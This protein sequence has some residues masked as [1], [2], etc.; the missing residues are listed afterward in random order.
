MRRPQ[1][2]VL[3]TFGAIFFLFVACTAD[4]RSASDRVAPSP[5]DADV[6]TIGLFD[7]AESEL[8]A[9]LYSQ[10]LEGAGFTVR[11]SWR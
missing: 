1:P 11:W 7:L 8:L 9:E 5:T 2:K 3:R 4:G 10:A 6:I